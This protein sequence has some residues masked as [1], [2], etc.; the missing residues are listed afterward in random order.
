MK[1]LITGGTGFVGR[2]LA[3]N[4]T[5]YDLAVLGRKELDLL[6]TEA[7]EVYLKENYFDVI[8]HSANINTSRNRDTTQ[9]ASL[10]GNLRMFFNLARCNECYG[11]MYYFGS[12]AEYDMRHYIPEMKEDY[13]DTYVPTDP[14]GF[15][16]YIMSK[17]VEEFDNIYDLRLFGVYGKY[18]EYE[19]RF[20]SNAI[21]RALKDKDITIQQNVFFD[22]LWVED[23]AEIMKWFI[24]NKPLHKHYNVCRGVK[25][26]LY[27]LAVMVRE[28]LGMNCDI[29]VDREG[30]KPEYTGDNGRLLTEIGNFHYTDFH[31]SLEKL[32]QFYK[33]NLNMI[34]ESELL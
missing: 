28:I 16:K 21:C 10:D 32:C 27:S 13:F 1:V 29:L 3:E 34:N 31:T 25:I 17:S 5:M 19:R 18:E 24:E 30:W 9:Y 23:L 33:E 6:D 26:D 20:I 4:L 7:V 15:S 8:I 22:Y 14:Y 12:G 11:K 2:N